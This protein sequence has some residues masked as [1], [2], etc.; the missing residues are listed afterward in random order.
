MFVDGFHEQGL[1]LRQCE[2]LFRKGIEL[3][4]AQNLC[5]RGYTLH[6]SST[7]DKPVRPFPA[8][9]F[10]IVAAAVLKLLLFVPELGKLTLIVSDLGFQFGD[11]LLFGH[12][13]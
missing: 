13:T 2:G 3:S 4:F 6:S 8:V 1:D 9:A 12:G 5:Q 10:L 7:G 11:G